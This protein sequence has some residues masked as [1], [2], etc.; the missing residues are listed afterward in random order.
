LW[1]GAE[2]ASAR[3][4][5]QALQYDRY[6]P[7]YPLGL[8]DSLFAQAH[9]TSNDV[10]VEIGAGTG[11]AT[12]PMVERGLRVFAV[13]PAEDLADLAR[14]KVRGRATHL[15]GRFEDVE[16]PPQARLVSAFNAWHWVEPGTGLERAAQLLGAGDSLAL[17]WTEV[18]SW[19][20][21]PFEDRLATIFGAPW[22]KE[23]PHVEGSL[24]PVRTDPRFD[25]LQVFHH[26]FDRR[27][28]GPTYVAVTQT[29]G[30][31]R[32]ARQYQALEDVIANEFGGRVTK[33]EDAVLYISKRL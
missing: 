4:A 31:E 14:S 16:L 3:F 28:D 32:S 1:P 7:P 9:L 8:F 25:D 22:P 27:L 11:L 26:P 17:V 21:P 30:G 12:L 33:K 6:R 19:G 20:E 29:Y 10:V 2:A 13:E 23:M 5:A 24:K 18:R 15:S